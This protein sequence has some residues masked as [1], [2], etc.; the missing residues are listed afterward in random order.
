MEKK[1]REVEEQVI[2]RCEPTNGQ[3]KGATRSLHKALCSAPYHAHCKHYIL[4]LC[5]QS[6][7]QGKAQ[8]KPSKMQRATLALLLA[9][10]FCA[11]AAHAQQRVFATDGCIEAMPGQVRTRSVGSGARAARQICGQ[12]A[13]RAPR[14]P[15]TGG[16]ASTLWFCR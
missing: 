9:V 10:A 2:S 11:T 13:Q 14:A 1:G 8:H 12:D 7:R 6:S 16:D 15:A 3:I 5:L 4:L